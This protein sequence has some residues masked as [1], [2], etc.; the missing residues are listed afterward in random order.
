MHSQRPAQFTRA[1]TV[2]AAFFTAFALYGISSLR[3]GAS[4]IPTPADDLRA[5]WTRASAADQATFSGTL[6]QI[7][8]PRAVAGAIGAQTQRLTLE[9]NGQAQPNG[10]AQLI[11]RHDAGAATRS[12]TVS[13]R[14]GQTWIDNG[15]GKQERAPAS[16]LAL[17]ATTN[18][19]DYLAAAR[20][21]TYSDDAATNERRYRFDLDR[22]VLGEQFAGI[23]RAGA[24]T[25][26]PPVFARM[27][28]NGELW[29]SLENG[30][31]LRQHVQI[32]LPEVNASHDAR[33]DL[34]VRYTALSGAP[35]Q[36]L[37]GPDETL[38]NTTRIAAH[39]LG[40][41]AAGGLRAAPAL[42]AFVICA[43][44]LLMAW[45]RHRRAMRQGIAVMLALLLGINPA[46]DALQRAQ[47]AA[48]PAPNGVM[49]ALGLAAGPEAGAI[50]AA[51]QKF[52]DKSSL[53]S[54]EI[55]A[56][57]TGAAGVDSDQDGLTDAQER[58]LGTDPALAD[59][60]G[61]LIPDGVEVRG[62]DFTSGSTTVRVYSD[63]LQPDSNR[64]GLSD[65]LEYPQPT[66]HAPANTHDYDG[67]GVPN[68]WD[69]DNDN[70]GVRDALDLSPFAV[71][72]YS[73]TLALRLDGAGPAASTA[74]IE[75]LVQPKPEGVNTQ[76]SEQLRYYG[77]TL[78]W[79]NGDGEG[80]ITD[81]DNSADDLRALPY[82]RVESAALPTA[83][84]DR[85]G[86]FVRE[87]DGKNVF[88][89]PL[90]PREQHG[91]VEAFYGKVAY[92][93]SELANGADWRASVVW[94]V[95][96]KNDRVV[97]CPSG[98]PAG[99][100][101]LASSTG[102]TQIYPAGQFRVA[103]MQVSRSRNF[104]AVAF[105]TPQTPD[106]DQTLFRVI[107]GLNKSFLQDQSYYGQ[108]ASSSMLLA[109]KSRFANGSDP[110]LRFGIASTVTVPVRHVTAAHR[111]RGM[112]ALGE[113]T[114]P[115]LLTD[116]YSA[117]PVCDGA[118]CAALG[119]A[120][121]EESGGLDLRDLPAVGGVLTAN[122]N[123]IVM[124]TRRGVRL[125]FYE[126]D[127]LGAWQAVPQASI[128]DAMVLTYAP[129]LT[130]G[131]GRSAV[132]A[133]DGRAMLNEATAAQASLIVDLVGEAKLG[134]LS[135]VVL[136]AEIIGSSLDIGE[137]A[138]KLKT[139]KNFDT[140]NMKDVPDDDPADLGI[141]IGLNVVAIGYGLTKA[142]FG[143]AAFAFSI[144]Q[145]V[146]DNADGARCDPGV[147]QGF[148]LAFAAGRVVFAAL[149]LTIAVFKIAEL[150]FD[151]IE[152]SMSVASLVLSVVG[153]VLSVI[154][155]VIAIGAS[156]VQFGLTVGF[157]DGD[158]AVVKTAVAA[159]VLGIA[160]T[161]ILLLIGLVPVA[162]PL[163]GGMFAVFEG[164]MLLE[165]TLNGGG[166][167]TV[168]EHWV[169][170]F[171]SA[172]QYTELEDVNFGAVRSQLNDAEKGFSTGNIMR[173][174]S[175]VNGVIRV[176]EDG[177]P[178]H[179][180][181][182]R[183]AARIQT[184]ATEYALPREVNTSACRVEGSRLLCDSTAS[185][186]FRLIA[187]RRNAKLIYT[188]YVEVKTLYADCTGQGANCWERSTTATLPRDDDRTPAILVIDVLPDSINKLMQWD[189]VSNPDRDGDGIG[190]AAEAQLG[191]DPD[192]P[193]SDGDG[194]SDAYE[195]A[196]LG[197]AG[198]DPTRA[199]SD[200][201]GINDGLELRFG[202]RANAPDSDN[203]GLRD[204]DRAFY[205]RR[206]HRRLDDHVARWAAN[207]RIP[208]SV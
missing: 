96:A 91:M 137:S 166:H 92:A 180:R 132:A 200:G 106:E 101:C 1:A 21:V 97:P 109:F 14:D 188:P 11:V 19:L 125:N 195:S 85:Y 71:T 5:V 206:A 203:D 28:G 22:S 160:W 111:D 43:C 103:G 61:D 115:T 88:Y 86:V 37:R 74:Y 9:I 62:F 83:E 87:E 76:Y 143:L 130:W 41:F 191:T 171:Y 95:L 117:A 152:L 135:V 44:A 192:N 54:A 15:N 124:S 134:A 205:Q 89:A 48:A 35:V 6:E 122:S 127:G 136:V 208:G 77:A 73:N 146:C 12:V 147:M 144:A 197:R 202:S 53:S 116:F 155:A 67:D 161:V 105:G 50:D 126:K 16:D 56:C 33:L 196:T 79:P 49:Q 207:T 154:G 78:D 112:G 170:Y 51:I 13:R 39:N 173:V 162:G 153:T 26:L 129:Y 123:S 82:L 204:G 24:R 63:P 31:P 57:G 182:S 185:A 104:E 113:T 30:L 36:N 151:G 181:D 68:L 169:S 4:I 10:D 32:S 55:A 38:K 121:Q 94:V 119:V 7:A 23:S 150:I 178:D 177:T 108:D 133:I 118:P 175:S 20:N 81:L 18:A 179:L 60:D 139:I 80:Q 159:L 107:F 142:A 3:T 47:A 93:P 114:I 186:E 29:V 59:T 17:G 131:V 66:G 70:D 72:S 90:A 141:G 58:C 138:D 140:S 199:D 164:L 163:I 183:V 42:F 156:F 84:Q 168:V 69:D 184:Q 167:T 157:A 40:L 120:Y 2:I 64:D 128:A 193:D 190:N 27:S 99:K 149:D 201:D 25:Q 65:G 100:T 75:I 98:E 52:T 187:P 8:I 165:S 46:L 194:L 110:A 158:P 34:R 176:A 148:N 45:S 102:I 189:Q 198:S 172:E 174:T 145:A